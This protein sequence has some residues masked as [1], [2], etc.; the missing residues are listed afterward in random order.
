MIYREVEANEINESNAHKVHIL[1][2]KLGENAKVVVPAEIT[3]EEI[4][5]AANNHKE[6]IAKDNSSFDFTEGA[7]WALSKLTES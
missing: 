2:P 6:E 4:K 5:Q 7:K 3:E 1:I